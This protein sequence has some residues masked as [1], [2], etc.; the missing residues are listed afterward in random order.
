[1]DENS[2]FNNSISMTQNELLIAMARL[3]VENYTFRDM[4]VELQAH[5][6]ELE[7]P[8]EEEGE[9]ENNG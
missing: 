3:V 5:I 7:A 1:M 2:R 6:K 9:E 8:K 4:V